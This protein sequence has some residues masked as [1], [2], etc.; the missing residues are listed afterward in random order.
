MHSFNRRES[1]FQTLLDYNNYLEEVETLTF[2][3]L[4]NIDLTRTEATLDSYA[5]QN[6]QDIAS[7]SALSAQENASTEANFAAQKEQAKLRREAARKED[8]DERMEREEGRREVLEKIRRGDADAD[9][10]T[11]VGLKKPS[12]RR[13]AI[14]KERQQ[15]AKADNGAATPLFQIQGLKPVEKP[16]PEE[17]YDPFDGYVL[18]QEYYLLQPQ[19]D[20]SWL[21][22]ARTD[23][24][25]RAGGYDVTEYC[26]RAMLEAFAG[27]GIFVEEEVAGRDEAASKVV[28]TESAA[29]AVGYGKDGVDVL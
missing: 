18:K 28:G 2:N 25:I 8:V 3:L 23:T 1:E 11:K 21:D 26:T 7:N 29:L 16:K 10:T 14:A 27:L 17:V 13:P 20:H 6:A 19:Y 24:Q 9:K 5:K 4:N 22:K 12:G 15:A